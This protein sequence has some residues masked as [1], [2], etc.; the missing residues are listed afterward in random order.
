ML[1]SFR[2]PVDAWENSGPDL[3]LVNALVFLLISRKFKRWR[4]VVCRDT[5]VTMEFL[6]P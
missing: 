4:K 6:V 1:S 5:D 3:L 2:K